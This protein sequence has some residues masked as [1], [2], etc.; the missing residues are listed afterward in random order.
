MAQ[1]F[2]IEVAQRSS[3]FTNGPAMATLMFSRP[4]PAVRGRRPTVTSTLSAA[5]WIASPSFVVTFSLP[6]SKPPAFAPSSSFTPCF[7]SHLVTGSVRALS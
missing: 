4:Q 1:T 5:S 6:F 3:I 2:F 7:S